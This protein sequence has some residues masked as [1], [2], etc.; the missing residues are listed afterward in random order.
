MTLNEPGSPGM[1]VRD[2]ISPRGTGAFK[3]QV[4]D[5]VWS[6]LPPHTELVAGCQVFV[7]TCLQVGR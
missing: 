4:V 1:N 5:D 3:S 7:T 2:A 6:L